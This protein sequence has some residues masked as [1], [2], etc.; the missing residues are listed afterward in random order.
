LGWCVNLC[1]LCLFTAPGS[2]CRFASSIVTPLGYKADSHSYAQ[3]M[4]SRMISQGLPPPSLRLKRKRHRETD[5]ENRRELLSLLG[6]AFPS[7]SNHGGVG[8]ST[9]EVTQEHL[10]NLVCQGYMTAVELMTC[11]MPEDPISIVLTGGYVVSCVVFY[12]RG[13]GVPS[14]Q[15][16]R[17]LL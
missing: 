7:L 12:E 13:F 1:L 5:L 6:V 15:F 4:S 2:A 8:W 3:P 17:S 10:Q 16:L 11:R 9:S 14:H